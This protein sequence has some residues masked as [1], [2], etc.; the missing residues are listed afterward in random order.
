M[1]FYQG[2]NIALP[3]SLSMDLLDNFIIAV[4]NPPLLLCRAFAWISGISP[5]TTIS[6]LLLIFPEWTII[7][8]MIPI[9]DVNYIPTG[10]SPFSE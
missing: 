10:V 4:V 3:A 9:Q 7:L 8:L 2:F 5:G 6:S 1:K